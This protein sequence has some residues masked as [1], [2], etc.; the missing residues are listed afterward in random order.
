MLTHIL[1]KKVGMTQMFTTEG[2]LI[3]VTV[4]EAGPCTVVQVKTEDNDGYTAAQIGFE[5]VELK[6]N[7]KRRG[8]FTK[9]LLGHFKAAGLENKP[10]RYLREVPCNAAEPPKVGDTVTVKDFEGVTHVDVVGTT[11]GRGFAGTI[12]RHGFTAGPRSHG[13]MNVRAPGSIGQHQDPGRVFPGKKLPGH[14]GA[15]RRTVRNLELVG[16][17]QAKNLMFLKGAIPGSRG[18]QLMIRKTNCIG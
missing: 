18:G 3:A 17:D 11:K 13:S 7:G 1:G 2:E 9:P 6:K 8:R 5:S 12:K 16:L 15:A 10:L 14:Y 4:V